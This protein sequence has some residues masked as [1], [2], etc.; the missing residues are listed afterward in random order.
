MLKLTN[1]FPRRALPAKESRMFA[2]LQRA[3]MS[4]TLRNVPERNSATSLTLRQLQSV[5][6]Y[7]ARRI[8][9]E[10]K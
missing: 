5:Q 6:F 2:Y 4:D 1:D 7:S 9:P 10:T 3:E 8:Q